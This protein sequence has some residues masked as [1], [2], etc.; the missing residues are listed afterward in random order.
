M[1][2]DVL[3]AK[4]T[5]VESVVYHSRKLWRGIRVTVNDDAKINLLKV[6]WEKRVNPK[7]RFRDTV[8][9]GSCEVSVQLSRTE[10]KVL[11]ALWERA[12][13]RLI[14]LRDSAKDILSAAGMGGLDT[15]RVVI[16]S[17]LTDFTNNHFKA[18]PQ[19]RHGQKRRRG[20]E[21]E[22]EADGRY[23]KTAKVPGAQ[24]AVASIFSSYEKMRGAPAAVHEGVCSAAPQ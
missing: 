18:P 7:L 4:S 9:G 8:D 5:G 1:V 6:W 15:R 3:F 22:V 12:D 17:L 11:E 13:K 10:A 2:S 20:A 23:D 16:R 24:T 19:N 21:A 14:L